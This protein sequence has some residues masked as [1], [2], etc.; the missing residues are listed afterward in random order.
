MKNL[1]NV[2]QSQSIFITMFCLVL[3]IEQTLWDI[4]NF[5]KVWWFVFFMS[6]PPYFSVWRWTYYSLWQYKLTWLSWKLPSWTGLLLDRDSGTRPS[7]YL[8]IW[9]PKSWESFWLQLWLPGGG[10]C[11]FCCPC[12]LAQFLLNIFF[13]T[14]IKSSPGWL[15]CSGGWVDV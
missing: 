12:Q 11:Y 5:E 8:C 6:S 3:L 14:K 10:N 13:S 15:W 7:H 2:C 4:A 9:D 1:C